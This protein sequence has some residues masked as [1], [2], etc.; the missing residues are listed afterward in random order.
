M[1]Q[2]WMKRMTVFIVGLLFLSLGL[3]FMIVANFGASPWDVLHVG[4][5]YQFGLSIGTWSII[6]GFLILG[7]SSIMM[8]KMPQYGA[9]LNMLLVGVFIDLFMMIPF[10]VEPS[11]WV[12]KFVMFMI[13][14]IVHAYG[15]GIYLSAKM[16]A[17]PRDSFMLALREKTGWSFSRVRRIMEVTVLI[18]GWLLGGPVFIG[19]VI[20]S[21]TLGI[22][23][24]LAVPQCQT[25]TDKWLKNVHIEKIA[26]DIKRG[27]SG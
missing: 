10:L 3:V 26:N 17:G 2:Y 8:K 27:V 11:H 5:F 18:I 22:F 13:G 12:G 21:L 19:T 9:Y 23:I 24:D 25:L 15:M 14:M 4:L 7:S 20:F 1:T 16:G 6:V